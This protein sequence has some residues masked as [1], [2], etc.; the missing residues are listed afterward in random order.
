MINQLPHQRIV[1]AAFI[2]HRKHHSHS[3][4]WHWSVKECM[5]SQ[6]VN[7]LAHWVLDSS[8]GTYVST[9]FCAL[10]EHA[11]S[12][13]QVLMDTLEQVKCYCLAFEFE[14][15]KCLWY[16]LYSGSE[17]ESTLFARVSAFLLAICWEWGECQVRSI[18]PSFI[19]WSS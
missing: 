15:V 19:L 9:N 4:S 17:S 12:L 2:G 8:H 10:L 11:C 7:L 3:W 1:P 6:S 13:L 5:M 18:M 14:E 16:E